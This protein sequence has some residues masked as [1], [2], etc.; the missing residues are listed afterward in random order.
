MIHSR[1]MIRAVR[2]CLPAWAR[3]GRPLRSAAAAP[4]WAVFGRSLTEQ[5]AGHRDEEDLFHDPELAILDEALDYV[6]EHGWTRAAISA[7]AQKL[8]YPPL[9]HGMFEKGDFALVRH[10]MRRA[11]EAMA[12][13]LEAMPL[14]AMTG[15]E[16]I[17]AGVRARLE[18]LAPFVSSGSWAKAMALG[19]LPQHALDT[20]TELGV[21]VDELWYLAGDR[22][23][24]A[25]W[26]SR[27]GLL[28]G[29]FASTELYMLS[30]TSEG[31]S[32]TWEF[33]RRRV[34]DVSLLGSRAG[35][36]GDVAAAFGSGLSSL[37]GGA[38]SL[39]RPFVEAQ[40]GHHSEAVHSALGSLGSVAE[41]F[42]EA[43][44]DAA[45]GRAPGTSASRRTADEPA[46]AASGAG[47]AGGAQG[48]A[49]A[50]SDEARKRDSAPAG[51]GTGDE[52]GAS[53]GAAA[54]RA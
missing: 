48:E 8:G 43:V 33:L 16:R 51:E 3:A 22:S 2:R 47:A 4:N 15:D 46:E 30:D 54:D 18:H 25:S 53:D 39:A 29:V 20:S 7:G 23:A 21:T 17:I 31:F 50:P 26:Y 52:A 37:A 32:D 27:R 12:S 19:A 13:Q 40:K 5:A 1:G 10:A 34:A 6:E 28:L 36:A 41:L 45:A 42:R 24:D 11:T 44:A 9:S 49:A 14:E 35:S 38:F